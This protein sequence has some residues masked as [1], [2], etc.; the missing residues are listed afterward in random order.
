M[1]LPSTFLQL[2]AATGASLT[3]P[4]LLSLV[5]VVQGWVFAGRRTLTG[6]AG[7]CRRQH[8]EALLG[9]LP[10]VCDSVLELGPG[11]VGGDAPGAAAAGR[12]A[13]PVDVG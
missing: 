7:G 13:G 6:G 11:R 10:A 1:G 3:L 12:R 4:S 5:T 8:L 2:L 9:L